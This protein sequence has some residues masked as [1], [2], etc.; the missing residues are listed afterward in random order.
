[1]E[2]QLKSELD[3]VNEEEGLVI[4]YLSEDVSSRIIEAINAGV[5]EFNLQN[6]ERLVQSEISA[7]TVY[8]TH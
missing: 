2:G 4:E 8:L 1:M 7:A 6:N 3:E 5:E